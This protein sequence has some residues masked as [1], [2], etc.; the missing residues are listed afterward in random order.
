M[1]LLAF[2]DKVTGVD[3]LTFIRSARGIRG[4][5]IGVRPPASPLMSVEDAINAM[6]V[7]ILEQLTRVD[8]EGKQYNAVTAKI[9]APGQ[10]E[11]RIGGLTMFNDVVGVDDQGGEV[12]MLE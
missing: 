1:E 10:P 3:S 4:G 2:D 12:A 11:V 5:I 9:S 7:L 6:Y 8:Q